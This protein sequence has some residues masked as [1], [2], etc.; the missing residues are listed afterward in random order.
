MG[1][2][3]ND[4]LIEHLIKTKYFLTGIASSI[5]EKIVYIIFFS[6]KKVPHIT[7]ETLNL[8]LKRTKYIILQLINSKEN[9]SIY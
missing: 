6:D 9:F 5:I 4:I 3:L 1:E 2:T 8:E 7:V